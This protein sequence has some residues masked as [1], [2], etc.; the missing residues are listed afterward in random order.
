METADIEV[1]SL[2]EKFDEIHHAAFHLAYITIS[3]SGHF[4]DAREE[5]GDATPEDIDNIWAYADGLMYQ[6]Y[7]RVTT[8]HCSLK[9]S[10][11]FDI[12]EYENGLDKDL[13]RFNELL[14]VLPKIRKLTVEEMRERGYKY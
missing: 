5:W 6:A 11:E 2:A 10:I 12:E 7:E 14:E 3:P 4:F 1:K 8:G 9:A 13:A